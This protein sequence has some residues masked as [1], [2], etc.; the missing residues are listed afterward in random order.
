MDKILRLLFKPDKQYRSYRPGDI[1]SEDDAKTLQ[2]LLTFL[3]DGKEFSYRIKLYIVLAFNLLFFPYSM[4]NQTL[5]L[6]AVWCPVRR[7]CE[8]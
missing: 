3:L 6:I 4:Q 2:P 7:K 1:T 8:L 5:T